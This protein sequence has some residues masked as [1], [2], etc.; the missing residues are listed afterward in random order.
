VIPLLQQ[1]FPGVERRLAEIAD[2]AQDIR[3]FIQPAVNNWIRDNVI[4]KS[5]DHIVLKKPQSPHGTLEATEAVAQV[6]REKDIGFGRADILRLFSES[7]RS[8][9]TFLLPGGW[10]FCP[11]RDRIAILRTGARPKPAAVDPCRLRIPG[12]TTC[13]EHGWTVT[14]SIEERTALPDTLDASNRE[15]WLDAAAAGTELWCRTVEEKDQFH[16]L[17]AASPRSLRGYLKK[18][19]VPRWERE[20]VG[21]VARPEGAVVWIPAHALGHPFRVTEHTERVLRLSCRRNTSG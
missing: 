13:G 20:S 17:G 15:V 12:T 18:Q 14:A 16:P 11:G 5:D 2:D 8:D 19:G 9:G 10:R 4:E 3:R 1:Q 7:R 6:L 21:V